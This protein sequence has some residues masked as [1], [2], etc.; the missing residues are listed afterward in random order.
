MELYLRQQFDSLLFTAVERWSERLIQHNQ[1]AARALAR[2]RDD[3]NAPTVRRDAFV[4]ALFGEFL[5]D[6]PA[7]AC[8]ILEALADEP[9]LAM[10]P[11]Q[12]IG[13]ALSAGARAAFAD[14]LQRKTEELLEQ[15]T[16]FEEEA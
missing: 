1:G 6:N 12:T 11:G 7:G 16:L 14:L 5:L 8:F 4:S 3:A 13:A 2:L 10:Q 15:S 9:A